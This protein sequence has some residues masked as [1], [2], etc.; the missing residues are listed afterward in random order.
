MTLLAAQGN[1]GGWENLILIVVLIA[2]FY[3]FMIRPQTKRQNEIKKFREGLKPGDNVVTAGGIYGKIKKV[4]DTTFVVEVTSGV[5]LTIDKN[6]VY[7]SALEAGNDN[8]AQNQ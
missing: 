6:S 4:Q 5:S 7:P 1:A 8:Q 3:F 2:I